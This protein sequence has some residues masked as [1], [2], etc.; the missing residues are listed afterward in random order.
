MRVD[1]EIAYG[2]AMRETTASS[3]S[4][5]HALKSCLIN[6]VKENGHLQLCANAKLIPFS[7]HALWNHMRYH[8]FSYHTVPAENYMGFLKMKRER[9]NL[10]FSLLLLMLLYSYC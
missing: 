3:Q 1:A 9:K 8:Q 7:L 5:I 2:I 6:V 10:Q 4:V